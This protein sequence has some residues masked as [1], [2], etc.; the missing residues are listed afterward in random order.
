MRFMSII[1]L[2]FKI[3]RDI[4]TR[5]NNLSI[6]VYTCAIWETQGFIGAPGNLPNLCCGGLNQ[7]L[8]AIFEL[9]R[10]NVFLA[11]MNDT[12]TDASV[13]L[14]E[15]LQTKGIPHPNGCNI[16]IARRKCLKQAC[17]LDFRRIFLES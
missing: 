17:S 12:R 16:H 11:R 3:V 1:G 5:T 15:H 13:E 2:L 14:V 10:P 9:G 8:R 6:Q 4:Q 7:L